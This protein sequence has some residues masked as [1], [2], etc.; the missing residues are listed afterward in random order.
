[1]REV[2]NVRHEG[3]HVLAEVQTQDLIEFDVLASG[4]VVTRVSV[5]REYVYLTLR[6]HT[7]DGNATNRENYY[8]VNTW[9][10]IITRYV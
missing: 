4:E 7:T 5:N 3:K 10:D 1:M 9:L 2:Q 6:A 8:L